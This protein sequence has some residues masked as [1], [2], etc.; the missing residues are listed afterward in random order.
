M[1]KKYLTYLTPILLVVA[2]LLIQQWEQ[3]GEFS[4]DINR[5]A[6]QIIY[7][8]HAKCRMGC[9]NFTKKEVREILKN[10]T[11]NQRK[12]DPSDKPCPTFALEGMTSDGQEARMVFAACSDNALKLVTCIDLGRHYQCDCN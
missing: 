2:I 8:K 3:G 5:E 4:G 12:S 1:N 6:A 9:R 11:I 10:G 7:T